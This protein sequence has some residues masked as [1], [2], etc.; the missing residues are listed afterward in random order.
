MWRMEIVCTNGG[1]MANTTKWLHN[2]YT[3]T[4]LIHD[5]TVM[6]FSVKSDVFGEKLTL[7]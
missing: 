2:W 5:H 7:P 3:G 6:T 4:N 1:K